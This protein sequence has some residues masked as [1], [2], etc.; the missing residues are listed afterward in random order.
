MPQRLT[1]NVE[2]IILKADDCKYS[3]R[4]SI[5]KKNSNLIILSARIK[6]QTGDKE[7]IQSKVKEIISKRISSH[8]KGGS[9]GS[10]FINPVVSDEKLRCEFEG[11]TGKK[12]KDE[13]L[14]AGWFIDQLDLRG[15]TVGGAMV[16]VEHGNWIV[17]TG[18]ATAKDVI[19]LVS[20]IK[21]QVRDKFG[22]ELESEAQYLGF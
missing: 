4:Q 16:A 9:T 20:I 3:Y 15:K 1:Q 17:N 8:P 14:P 13:R 2:G 12:P 5:F 10:Y 7:E 21:Q 18:Q 22:I 19:M 11:D 6:L